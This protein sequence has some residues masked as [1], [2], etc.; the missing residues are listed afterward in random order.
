MTEV[1]GP[2]TP[3]LDRTSPLPSA[4]RRSSGSWIA[5]A[6][7]VCL[8]AIIGSL[9]VIGN[10]P[11]FPALD[12]FLKKEFPR[13]FVGNAGAGGPGVLFL[14]A[15]AALLAA[16]AIHEAGH[17]VA[18]LQA[19]FRFSSL[20]IG[21]LQIDRPFRVSF[22]RGRGAGAMAWTRMFPDDSDRL[23]QRTLMMATGGPV[24]SL[25][26]GIVVLLLPVPKGLFLF[27]LCALSLLVGVT[28]LIPFRSRAL[29]TDGWRILT[30]LQD[31]EG[32]E[33]WMAVI[34][35]GSELRKGVSPERLPDE[36][37]R[38]AIAVKDNT[39]DTVAAHA[40]AYASALAR[41]DDAR[42]AEYLE[43]CLQ[44]SGC[45][46]PLTQK[47]LMSD[48][49]VFQG[50]KRKRIDLARQWLAAIPAKVQLPWLRT[51]VEA[52]ILEAEGDVPGAIR[53]LEEVE[54]LILA[55]PNQVMREVA[56]RSLLRWKS[57]LQLS[58]SGDS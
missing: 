51:R 28:N 16:T 4:A 27:W 35:L 40:I 41:H 1:S 11:Y 8:G 21:P 3:I 5:S 12:S 25:L 37:L 52:A 44:Y 45:A 19:G 7:G 2:H 39:P 24:A 49:G 57:E 20:G 17:L 42:A 9:A 33:R 48:A 15:L 10:L 26:T 30:L 29:L 34:K 22:S 23:A 46:S 6:I 18:G 13:L 50:R 53:K 54:R 58:L 55:T 38:K 56:H 32:A 43:T 36:F 47:A 14:A 31:R